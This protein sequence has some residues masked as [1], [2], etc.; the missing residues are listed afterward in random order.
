MAE[1]RFK[2]PSVRGAHKPNCLR[3]GCRIYRGGGCRAGWSR[4][5]RADRRGVQ[6]H[7]QLVPASGG[8]V[9]GPLAQP[10]PVEPRGASATR[11]RS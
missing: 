6:T 9:S 5:H 4:P 7:D 11:R 10:W 3:N 8:G 2:S 1:A